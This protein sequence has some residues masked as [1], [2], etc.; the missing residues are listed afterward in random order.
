M[1]SVKNIIGKLMVLIV[2]IGFC[3]RWCSLF[4]VNCV[5]IGRVEVWWVGILGRVVMVGFFWE[6][7]GCRLCFLE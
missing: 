2:N 5:R 6:C 7:G 4:R 3:N 1:N